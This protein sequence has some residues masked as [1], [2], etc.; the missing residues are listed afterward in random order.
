MTDMWPLLQPFHLA[1]QDMT[2]RL[3]YDINYEEEENDGLG[4][5][6]V[7]PSSLFERTSSS[8]SNTSTIPETN[9]SQTAGEKRC[10]V[11][12]DGSYMYTD[13]TQPTGTIPPVKKAR[14]TKPPATVPDLEATCGELLAQMMRASKLAPKEKF[15]FTSFVQRCFYLFDEGSLDVH[16]KLP[17]KMRSKRPA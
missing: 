13:E 7:T 1:T 16:G 12:L 17:L 2:Q 11:L 4:Y 14:T 5:T 10:P 6:N 15:A 9:F 3:K 8:S